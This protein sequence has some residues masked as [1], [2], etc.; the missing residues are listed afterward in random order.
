[1]C[2]RSEG[3]VEI[4][5]IRRFVQALASCVC[6]PVFYMLVQILRKIMQHSS[7]HSIPAKVVKQC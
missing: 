6:V 4:L 3:S 7:S 1:M 2:A 5:R